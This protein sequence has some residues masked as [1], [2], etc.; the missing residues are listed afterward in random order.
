MVECAVLF[1]CVAVVHDSC[2]GVYQDV[3]FA[4]ARQSDSGRR[5]QETTHVSRTHLAKSLMLSIEFRGHRL[6]HANRG[7]VCDADCRTPREHGT[8]HLLYEIRGNITLV[9]AIEK[10]V[11]KD[12]GM[13]EVT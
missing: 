13:R 3:D 6:S 1:R 4:C 8:C 2:C 5:K 12:G 11:S 7:V 9:L 10:S